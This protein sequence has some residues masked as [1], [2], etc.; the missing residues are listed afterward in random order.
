MKASTLGALVLLV[1]LVG[2]SALYNFGTRDTVIDAVVT[3]KER[4]V[5]GSG[6]T[7]SSTYLVFTEGE[8]FENTDSFWALKFNSSDVQG[9]IGVGETCDFDVYGWRVPFFSWYRNILEVNCQ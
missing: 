4:I 7:M 6:D 1:P 9:Q 5:S 8:V 2:C 3:D